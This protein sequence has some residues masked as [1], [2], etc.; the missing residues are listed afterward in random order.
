M[1]IE[2]DA[3]FDETQHLF[4]MNTLKKL[5][6]NGITY[7][8]K[9]HLQKY[10]GKH[11][12]EIF[13]FLITDKTRMSTI[14][15]VPQVGLPRNQKRKSNSSNGSNRPGA[16]PHAYDPSTVGGQSGCITCTQ[17]FKNRPGKHIKTRLSKNTK[18]NRKK[19]RNYSYPKMI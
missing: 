19:K 10:Y 12:G 7:S 14:T 5:E 1:I 11:D 16:V 8:D 3:P 4:K 18:G 13:P 6:Q 2:I 15:T 17:E 9:V